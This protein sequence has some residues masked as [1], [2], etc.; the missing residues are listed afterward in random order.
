MLDEHR[1]PTGSSVGSGGYPH[2][3]GQQMPPQHMPAGLQHP[4]HQQQEHHGPFQPPLSA[5]G[6]LEGAGA[7]YGGVNQHFD[8]YDPMLD[9]D[10]F[11]LSASMHFPTQFS[12]ETR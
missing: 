10:P 2:V 6:Q 11:G 4:P 8:P 7:M 5:A 1:D 9:A 12:Y 3:Y